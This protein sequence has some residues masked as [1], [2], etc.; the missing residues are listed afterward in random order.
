VGIVAMG[1]ANGKLVKAPYQGDPAHPD[2]EYYMKL[3]DFQKVHPPMTAAD[4]KKVTGIDYRFMQTMFGL[5][6][7][8]GKD[9]RKFMLDNG[10][11][12]F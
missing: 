4:V 5:D 7:A 8:S 9:I 10:R 11:L 6:T 2:E 1:K 3:L 12:T